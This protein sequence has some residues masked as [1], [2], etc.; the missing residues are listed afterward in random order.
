MVEIETGSKIPI[1]RTFW[2]NSM[3]CHR[4]ATCHIT[5]AATSRIQWQ[6]PGATCHIAG[7]CHLANSMSW[8]KSHVSHCRVLPPGE[9][10]CLISEPRATLQGAATWRIQCHVIP[11]PRATLHGAA[12]WRIQCHDNRATCHIAGCCRLAN[13]MPCHS[14]VTSHFA[15]CCHLA[16]SMSWSQSHVPHQIFRVNEF[17]PPYWK[18][19]F[20][21]FFVFLIQLGL[22]RAAAFVSSSIH[23]FTEDFVVYNIYGSFMFINNMYY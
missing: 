12:T 22:R 1:W 11:E 3:A 13:S 4:K 10:K 18:S 23:L 2:A 9:F 5:G 17:Y 7:C 20:A 16:N 8:S 14:R 19:F 6:D 15:K 21:V